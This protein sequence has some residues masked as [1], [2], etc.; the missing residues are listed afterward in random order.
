MKTNLK[1]FF[2]YASSKLNYSRTIPDLKDGNTT[3]SD[4]CEKAKTLNIF[5]TSV[6]TKETDTWPEFH[7][8]IENTIDT[9]SFTVDKVKSKLT[10]LNSC[11]SAGVNILHS[12]ILKE[13]SEEL[14][15]PLSIIFTKSFIEGSLLQN[16]KDTVVTPI[17]QKGEKEFASN[18]RPISLTC[19]ACKLME[20]IIKDKII[21]FIINN[22]LLTNLQHDFVPGK[23][24]QSNLLFMLN[25]LTGVIEHNLKVDL[26]YLDFYMAFD[27]VPHRK[28]IHKLEKY[29]IS[30]HLLLWIKDFLSNRRQQVRVTFAL[31]DWVSVISGVPHGSVF[32]PILF[33]LSMN[34]LPRDILAK[35]FL[36]ADDTKL[37]EVL[38]SAVCH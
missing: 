7:T 26:V 25:I 18:Y 14:S 15:T 22:N 38:F 5:F 21:S 31:S 30:G 16:W 35:L 11:K 10:E 12:R 28:L 34:D 33:I 23:S 6:F 27:Y 3:I 8:P 20:S 2:K 32:G 19:I 4:N 9:I 17:H 36:F 13:L 37:L 29:G 1:A 24:C